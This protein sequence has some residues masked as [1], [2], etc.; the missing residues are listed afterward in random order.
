MKFTV[1]EAMEAMR[2]NNIPRLT[3]RLTER[4]YDFPTGLRVTTGACALGQCAINLGVNAEALDAAF[5][6]IVI[7]VG[8]NPDLRGFITSRNDNL[9]F[10]PAKIAE[11]AL[12]YLT[13]EQLEQVLEV[14]T[15]F[16]I[17]RIIAS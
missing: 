2:Q 6:R 14:S 9:G 10:T 4:G 11:Q 1:A 8:M 16:S 15:E 7:S 5:S 17:V 12:K 13:K 3:G